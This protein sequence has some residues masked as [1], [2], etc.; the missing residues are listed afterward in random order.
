MNQEQAESMNEPDFNM[1]PN[2]TCSQINDMFNHMHTHFGWM[3]T[4]KG[5]K[6]TEVKILA[7]KMGL[8][9]LKDQIAMKIA[10][11]S[12]E[13]KK[14]DLR[15]LAKKLDKLIEVAKQ[16]LGGFEQVQMGG[17]AK[18]HKAGKAKSKSKSKSKSKGKKSHHARP[19]A[20]KKGKSKSK[21]KSKSKGKKARH[22]ARHTAME[23]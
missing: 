13:D 3:V 7:Y 10:D 19:K 4:C 12:N 20:A 5:H 23:W 17:A 14:K 22:T 21:S 1:M 8:M 16:D 6:G 11:T 9:H 15:I 2:M 18:K